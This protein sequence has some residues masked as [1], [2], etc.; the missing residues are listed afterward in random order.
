MLRPSSLPPKSLD[1]KALSIT[2]C[3]AKTYSDNQQHYAGRNVVNHCHIVGEVARALMLR[4]PD[5]LKKELFPYGSEL[6][7]ACHDLG[8]I[9]PTFQ[10]KIHDAL[11]RSIPEL[12][13][14]NASLEKQWGGHAGVSLIAAS[15]LAIGKF[16]PEIL[17]QHHGY[18]PNVVG[19]V[20]DAVYGGRAW[21]QKREQLILEL[22]KLL[23]CD[24]PSINTPEQALIIAGLTTVSDWIGS[25]SLFDNPDNDW[26]PLIHLAL[27]NAGFIAPQVIPNL[28]FSDIFNFAPKNSQSTFFHHVTQSGVYILEA[29]MGI[30]KTEAALYAAYQLLS[31]RDA[32]G[33][34]FALP[35]QLT[36]NKIHERVNTFLEKIL[37]PTSGHQN[38]LLLHSNAWLKRELAVEGN[39]NGSWFDQS[40]RG[41]LAPFAVGTI[42]QALMAVMNVKHGFVRTFGLA[43]KVVILDEVHSYDTYTGE[44]LDELVS[45]LKKL[46]CTV[47]I[48]SATLTQERRETLLDHPTQNQHY[49]LI[50]AKTNI[51]NF[52]ELDVDTLDAQTVTLSCCQRDEMA[53]D[54]ALARAESGQQ[55]LWIEN[56]V[57]QAQAIFRQ[58]SAIDV[59]IECGLLHSRFLRVD[60]ANN[61]QQWVGL[62]GKDNPRARQATG[63]ILVG[64]QVLE[65][66]L[67]IDA[68]FLVS[69]FAPTDFLFQRIG[70]LWRH[71]NERPRD[72]KRE[73]WLLTPD[74]KLAIDDCTLFGDSAKVYKP[75][76][77]CRSLAVWQ[78]VKTIVLPQQI[79]EFIEATYSPR[80]EQGNM[81]R[82]QRELERERDKLKQLASIG[83]SKA[84]QTLPESASTRYSEQDS[85]QVLLLRG[86]QLGND[87]TEMTLLNGDKLRLPRGVKASDKKQWRELAATILSN[88]VNVSIYHAPTATT[89]K[90][91]EWLR[92]FVYLGKPEFGESLLRVALVDEGGD[93]KSLSGG[94]AC[95]P[96]ELRYDERIG[97][98]ATKKRDST[99]NT[100][101]E[102]RK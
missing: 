15:D 36:S 89:M 12:A 98:C 74:L 102:D 91:L 72:A 51:G 66:S 81:L 19:L 20:N 101:K 18:L 44:L 9:S 1:I 43:G 63:R 96:Y 37:E 67:D 16:I 87:V 95:E 14:V 62:Y 58:L 4:M 29:P 41:I 26:K 82:Y 31:K 53:I 40:K 50:S 3:L 11:H 71:D 28:C 97:Y 56:T 75:Y 84:G 54:E 38:A 76:I 8:K 22:K 65:Q 52:Q 5:V 23:N 24:F 13:Q 21:Q 48:L 83:L 10:K 32:T 73:A 25:S 35:T 64:T 7:A 27:D 92:E 99:F 61:E 45:T 70:R 85:V 46:H 17:G 60:R 6:I 77:L 88:V 34:Y 59:S 33:V 93:I 100:N 30:G 39:P 78:T 94:V 47:I 57:A 90:D 79:R 86:Y 68:D 80:V 55:V 49:P 42:D 69:R 2:Q